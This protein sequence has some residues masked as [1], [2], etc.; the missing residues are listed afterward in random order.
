M[1]LLWNCPQMNNNGP[2]WCYVNSGS[3]NG[4]VPSDNKPLPEP[5]LIQ[6]HVVSLGHKA[7]NGLIL[8]VNT[9]VV[10]VLETQ[11]TRVSSA[12]VL[13]KFWNRDHFVN[14]PGQWETLHC[15]YKV[16]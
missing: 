8:K 5:I 10:D 1:Y 7:H 4:L 14:V 9:M 16:K 13:T 11:E 15:I 12:M 6:N 2:Y 3:G